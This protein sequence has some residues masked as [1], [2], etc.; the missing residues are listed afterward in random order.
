LKHLGL[1]L[2]LLVLTGCDDGESAAPALPVDMGD[3]AV[4]AEIIDGGCQPSPEICNGR[5]DDCDGKVDG[6]DDDLNEQL[7]ADPD[8]CGA[9]GVTCAA[10]NAET[11][12]ANGACFIQACE[13]GYSDYNADPVDGCESDCLITA[14]GREICD[15]VDNDCDGA[16]DESFDLQTDVAH[17]GACG[18]VCPEAEHGVSACTDGACGVVQC[19]RDWVDL[20]GDPAT[21][22]EYRCT[23]ASTDRIREF[24]NGRDDDCDG[25]VDEAADLAPPPEDL[26]GT[27][28]VCGAACAQDAHCDAGERCTDAGICVPMDGGPANQ[29]CEDDADCHAAHGGY[30]CLSNTQIID[31]ERVVERRCVERTAGAVCDGEAGFRCARPPTYQRGNE[32]GRC[33]GQDNDCDGRIDE[34]YAAALFDDGGRPR[35]CEVGQGACSR[36]AAVTCAPDGLGTLCTA[37]AAEPATDRDATCDTIDDDCDGLV[38]EDF[39]QAWTAQDGYE[40]F[41]YEASRPGASDAAPGVDP[42]PEDALVVYRGGKACSV[43]GVLPWANLTWVEARDACRAVDARLC[44]ADEWAG[45]CGAPALA[46]PYGEHFDDQTCNGGG[47]DVDPATP[48]LQD[49]A[50]PTGQLALCVLDGTYDLSG[51]LKEWTDDRRDGLRPVRGGGFESNVAGGLTCEQ[52]G[53]LKPQ[54]FRSAA[55]GFRCCR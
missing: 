1:L 49:A 37:Q 39:Q 38:D 16:V 23:P 48:G 17:C 36:A 24:C 25:V 27:D 54:D 10:D 47:Y 45:A 31:G 41:A 51:N 21:G 32:V 4:D 46:Y 14:G 30:S 42:D 12:C 40:I 29:P 34:D 13:F 52:R 19:D 33:D 8:N 50:L 3:A 15:T 6:D 22:C 55:V 9:C 2:G 53:D 5:D 20:D 18:N 43:P 28:G 11:I 7:F 44:T 26:C 35:Q